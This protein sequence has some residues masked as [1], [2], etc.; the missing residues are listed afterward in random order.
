MKRITEPILIATPQE[1]DEFSEPAPNSLSPFTP[2]Q[3]LLVSLLDLTPPIPDPQ[4]QILKDEIRLLDAVEKGSEIE[5]RFEIP[6]T[7]FFACSDL[8]R[9]G[10]FEQILKGQRD[11]GGWRFAPQQVPEERSP[12]DEL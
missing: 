11:V 2:H 6:W 1:N 7:A 12:T 5:L 3:N 8:H 9:N 4:V 10:R